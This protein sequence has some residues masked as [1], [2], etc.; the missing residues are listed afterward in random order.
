MKILITTCGVGIGHAS[1]D[2]ALAQYL[3]DNYHQI[4]F[5][6]YSSGLKY[7]KKFKYKTYS[8]PPMNF[9]GKD[10]EINIEESIKQSKDIPFT[11]IKSM[12]KES[13]I[14]KKSKPD[15][16]ITDSHYSIPITAKL[17]NIPC[18]VITND[19]RFGFSKST[20]Y[21]SIKYFEKSIRKFIIE[22]SKGCQRIF[23][24]DIPGSIE[25]PEEL[26]NKTN[27][28]GPLLH[29]QSNELDTKE[30]LRLKYNQNLNEKVIVVTIGGSEFGRILIENICQISSQ[31]NADKIFIFTGLEVDSNSFKN[32]DENKV[33]IREFTH[34]MVEWMK[35]SD[36]T[37]TLAGHTTS[38]ELISINKANI[39]IPISNHVEQERNTERMLKY[40]LTRSTEI[41][42]KE[43]LLQLIN[44]TLE[45]SDN[46][47]IDDEIYNEF[48]RYD[49][50]ENALNIIQ[51]NYYEIKQ[52]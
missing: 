41:N 40:G 26:K 47:R 6:S 18:Y 13:R 48:R 28:I 50:R 49:G 37:I 29:L 22:I 43:K 8:L 14:I 7:L 1:R 15:I 25:I 20:E 36:L 12:Y 38:M 32:F 19:L 39:M 9:E 10:G 35:L 27:H 42:N 34:N 3:E 44:D 4:E 24:P 21:K 46:I 33:I 30:N 17:L 52:I 31:I 51:N 16:I 45:Q 2:I 23:I 11:F 5:A